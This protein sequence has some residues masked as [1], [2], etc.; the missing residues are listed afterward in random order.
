MNC[1][2]YI[3][4]TVF[5][6]LTSHSIVFWLSYGFEWIN[7]PPHNPLPRLRRSLIVWCFHFQINI[8]VLMYVQALREAAPPGKSKAKRSQE[9]FRSGLLFPGSE[10]KDPMFYLDTVEWGVSESGRRD[11]FTVTSFRVSVTSQKLTAC[12]PQSEKPL[13]I[14]S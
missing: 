14:I 7:P 12:R 10:I 3:I 5:L 13:Y 9:S 4:C 8:S 1:N 6:R 11:W 2:I